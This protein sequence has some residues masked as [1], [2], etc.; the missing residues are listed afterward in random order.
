MKT[1][2]RHLIKAFLPHAATGHSMFHPNRRFPSSLSRTWSVAFKV[3]RV[4]PHP[5]PGA[6]IWIPARRASSQDPS[7][8]VLP[9]W[10]PAPFL[11]PPTPVPDSPEPYSSVAQEVNPGFPLPV[12]SI[13]SLLGLPMVS[14]FPVT[15]T[16][17]GVSSS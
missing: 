4:P 3:S 12:G 16:G 11:S 8:S 7:K 14:T 5:A 6:H 10:C 17:K 2:Q 15:I 13:G 9:S 1:N